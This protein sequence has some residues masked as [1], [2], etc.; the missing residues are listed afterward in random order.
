MG[1]QDLPNMN[2]ES[3]Y[4]G[5]H[6]LR[7]A[8]FHETPN[9]SFDRFQRIV[10][11]LSKRWE[12]SAPDE[13]DQSFDGRQEADRL[14]LTFDDGFESNYA[15]GRW[16][17]EQG[18]RAIFFIVPEFVGRSVNEMQI[19]LRERGVVAKPIHDDGNRRGMSRTQLNELMNMGHLI[20]AHNMCHR[21]FGNL[22]SELDLDVAIDE[23]LDTISDWT[24]ERCMDFAFAWG[25]DRNMTLM[26]ANRLI[27]HGVRVYSSIRGLNVAGLTGPVIWRNAVQVSEP[28]PFILAGIQGGMDHRVADV[29]HRLNS[30]FLRRG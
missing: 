9:A 2:R 25:R 15:A 12:M 16:L 24:G 4:G 28:L 23:V 10:V 18:I 13:I 14:M 22:H 20:A 17:A 6:G 11:A 29:R 19:A 3:L 30:M 1:A 27:K 26:A 5:H 7:I 21:D 8:T